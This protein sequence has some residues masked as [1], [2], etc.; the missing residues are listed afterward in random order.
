VKDPRAVGIKHL[1]AFVRE[2]CSRKHAHGLTS[3]GFATPP[4]VGKYG[5]RQSGYEGWR[6][7]SFLHGVFFGKH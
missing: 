4:F 5:G 7:R 2:G 6:N 1:A 3:R